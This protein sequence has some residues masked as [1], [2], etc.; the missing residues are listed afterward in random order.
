MTP[1]LRKSGYVFA[2]AAVL[3]IGLF[4]YRGPQ[5][6]PALVEKREQIK[7][8]Q[9]QNANL[10]KENESKRKRIE[11]LKSNPG[12]VEIEMRDRLKLQRQG[13]TSYIVPD[14]K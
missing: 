6:I 10:S 2:V 8:L 3:A 11:T 1:L 9:E 7:R 12:S 13:E 4:A 14:A 5:G